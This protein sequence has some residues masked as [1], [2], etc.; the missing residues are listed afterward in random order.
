MQDIRTLAESYRQDGS[1]L[2][3]GKLAGRMHAQR[4]VAY[5]QIL[6]LGYSERNSFRYRGQYHHTIAWREPVPARL[7]DGRCTVTEP[8]QM[9]YRWR[10]NA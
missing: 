9:T 1:P 7:G 5:F 6:L 4:P 2:R 10:W 8:T 3:N